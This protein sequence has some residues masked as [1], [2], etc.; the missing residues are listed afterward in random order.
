MNKGRVITPS[1]DLYTNRQRINNMNRIHSNYKI[2]R[3]IQQSKSNIDINNNS[4]KNNNIMR[5]NNFLNNNNNIYNN[6]NNFKYN[7]KRTGKVII[8]KYNYV[9]LKNRIKMQ[10]NKNNE[11]DF[12]LSINKKKG[13]S[14]INHLHLKLLFIQKYIIRFIFIKCRKE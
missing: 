6:N 2:K 5:S 14:D 8:E 9:P 7:Q 13:L 12:D 11:F 1:P 3:N 4:Q 10:N